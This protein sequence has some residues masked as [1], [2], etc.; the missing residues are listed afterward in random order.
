MLRNCCITCNSYIIEW[1]IT[2]NNYINVIWC[3]LELFEDMTYLKASLLFSLSLN[4]CFPSSHHFFCLWLHFLL[5]SFPNSR[6]ALEAS[7][8]DDTI[9]YVTD[10]GTRFS[11]IVVT[12]RTTPSLATNTRLTASV[13]RWR[14]FSIVIHAANNARERH[15]RTC[16]EYLGNLLT[17]PFEATFI[18]RCR[19][20][21]RRGLIRTSCVSLTACRC[22]L[23]KSVIARR[24]LRT[25]LS[26]FKTRAKVN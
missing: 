2:T 24:Q 4:R 15:W 7:N 21:Y 22:S 26:R 14:A 1:E 8:V 5:L 25:Q 13:R 3:L 10:P 17:E 11:S 23:P 18:R 16:Y 12:F 19:R 6:L 20:G 9:Y